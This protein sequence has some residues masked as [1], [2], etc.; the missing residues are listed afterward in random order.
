MPPQQTNIS[1]GIERDAARRSLNLSIVS[2]KSAVDQALA[3]RLKASAAALDNALSDKNA[4]GPTAASTRSV[5][6]LLKQYWRAFRERRQGPRLQDLSDRE[7]M[8]IGLTRGEIDHLTS[9]RAIDRL[10]NGAGY[11]WA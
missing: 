3:A 11:P 7:L 9:W 5:L 2:A 10:R 1:S 6:G 4:A 8:D